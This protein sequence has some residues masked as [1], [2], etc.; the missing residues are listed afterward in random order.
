MFHLLNYKAKAMNKV[1][2][3][4]SERNLVITLPQHLIVAILTGKKL[5]EVRK[6]APKDIIPGRTKV[7]MVQKGTKLVRGCFMLGGVL[8]IVDAGAAWNQ[9]GSKLAISKEW[10]IDYAAGSDVLKFWI[11]QDVHHFIIPYS[12]DVDFRISR[13]PQSYVY[14]DV[15]L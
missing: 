1:I 13:N 7:Y 12:L 11:V 8:S 6:R 14:T 2:K 5:Y 15:N 3:S 4:G 9:Y 10:F